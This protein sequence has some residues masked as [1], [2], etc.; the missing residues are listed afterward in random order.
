MKDSEEMLYKLL[1]QFVF[2]P[3]DLEMDVM[4]RT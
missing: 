4:L 2:F 1:K 3:L